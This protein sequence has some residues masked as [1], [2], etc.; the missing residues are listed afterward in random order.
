MKKYR[1]RVENRLDAL[2]RLMLADGYTKEHASLQNLAK[3]RSLLKKAGY[4]FE[5]VDNSEL[6][7]TEVN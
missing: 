7:T 1:T 2:R 4:T 3:L 6:P 5:P